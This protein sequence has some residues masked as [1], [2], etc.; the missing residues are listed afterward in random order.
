MIEKE[1]Q[2]FLDQFKRP[3]KKELLEKVRQVDHK[4]DV[5]MD[6]AK[7]VILCG[8]Q[9]CGCATS[10]SDFDVL[11]IMSTRPFRLPSSPTFM[12]V[13]VEDLKEKMPEM[14]NSAIRYGTWIKGSEDREK[15]V[16]QITSSYLARK[17]KFI[18]VKAINSYLN[19]ES[20]S[21][22]QLKVNWEYI[23]LHLI[24]L[25]QLVS[26]RDVTPKIARKWEACNSS[27]EFT[28][29]MPALLG[30]EA[31]DLVMSMVPTKGFRTPSTRVGQLMGGCWERDIHKCLSE[32]GLL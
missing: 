15:Y 14:V 13:A 16:Q 24:A 27:F 11:S 28:D 2:E 32:H 7:E 22:G 19:L 5:Y 18:L 12:V 6:H 4:I 10:D 3:S 30:Q 26:G 23:F 17:K 9:A 20:L 31:A 1:V 21:E 8:S 25:D 29:R